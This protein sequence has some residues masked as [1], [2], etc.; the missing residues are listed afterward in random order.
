VLIGLLIKI[1]SKGPVL[2][3]QWRNGFNQNPFMIYKFRSMTVTEEGAAVRQAVKNDVRVTKIGAF[4]RRWN[5]DELP[6]IVNVIKGNMSLVGPRPHPLNLDEA[7]EKRVSLYARRFN[8]KPGMTGW[9]QVN[10]ARG[11]VSDENSMARRIELDLWYMDHWSLAL[12]VMIMIKTVTS[13]KAFENA[14]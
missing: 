8:I 10:G 11:S 9:A 3:T 12:D 6:Q 1:E 5:L 13:K 4:I 7:E 2:F 14:F